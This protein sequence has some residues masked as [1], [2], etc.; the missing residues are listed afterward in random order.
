MHA[1]EVDIDTDLVRRLVAAQH[2]R[3]ASLEVTPVL[4]GGT[5]NALYRLGSELVVRLPR[6][7]VSVPSL[8]KELAYLPRLRDLPLAIPKVLVRGEPGEGYPFPWAVLCWV[9]GEMATA[10][11]LA[12]PDDAMRALAAF[13]HT[14]RRQ[15]TTGGPPPGGRGGPLAPRDAAMRGAVGA[16]GE[17]IDGRAVLALWEDAL[18]APVWAGPGVWIHGDLDSRNVLASGG[19]IC[20]VVDWGSCAVGDPACDVMVAWKMVPR[21]LRDVFRQLLAVDDATWRRARGWVLSQALIALGYYTHENNAVLVDE[22][23]R[24]LNEV[25]AEAG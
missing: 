17:C 8:E 24:W 4:P 25:L 23:W 3:W 12:D 16:M 19:R 7:A 15:E 14:L 6:H 9:A 20:G 21:G 1:D 11:H 2:P 10:E 13:I 22:A 5:D 18:A